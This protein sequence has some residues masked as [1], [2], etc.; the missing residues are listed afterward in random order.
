MFFLGYS[1]NSLLHLLFLAETS[2]YFM[3]QLVKGG[4]SSLPQKR[5]IYHWGCLVK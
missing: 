1:R 4:I 3:S 2:S 5:H